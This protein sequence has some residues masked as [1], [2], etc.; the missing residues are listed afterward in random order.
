MIQFQ[1]MSVRLTIT[2]KKSHLETDIFPP[3]NLTDNNYE[4]GLIYFSVFNSIP[5]VNETNNVFAYNDGSSEKQIIIPCGSYDLQDLTN[6]INVNAHDVELKMEANNN[7]LT[8]SMIC[9]K[10]ID[11]QIHNSI[12]RLLGFSN[13]KLEANKWHVSAEPINILPVSVIRIECD[14]VQGSY[15]NGIASHIIYEFVPNVPPGHRFIEK[16]HNVVYLPVTGTNISHVSIKLL[17]IDGN[18][19][20]FRGETVQLCLHLRAI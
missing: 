15:T 16:P 12:G 9:T 19:L 13:M 6:Y 11:F 8:C 2:G 20:D 7:T 10:T 14:I 3:L 4:C 1:K 5:N 17:D 18:F